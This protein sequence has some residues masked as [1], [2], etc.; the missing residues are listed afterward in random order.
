MIKEQELKELLNKL[1]DTTTEPVS[2]ALGD[3]IKR[4]IP[5][6]LS[7][8]RLGMDTIN[9]I[10]HLRINKL[11]AAAAI[12]ITIIFCATIL[13]GRD[14]TGGV[15]QDSMLFIKHWATTDTTGISAIKS[16]YDRLL[17]RG[18]DVVW[19]GD[20]LT[21]KDSSAVLMQRKL[22]DGKYEVM[23]ADGHE[24]QVTAEEL[25]PLLSRMLQK[26]AK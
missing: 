15:L 1:S 3:D 25:I 17:G 13:D 8:H 26:K 5:H 4:Q 11:A 23:F 2:P 10:I 7:H 14:S 22:S 19:Y 18:E 12:I 20:H 24:K 16:R 9:I 21:T 6:R